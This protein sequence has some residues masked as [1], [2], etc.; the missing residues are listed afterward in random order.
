M[1]ELLKVWCLNGHCDEGDYEPELYSTYE[2]AKDAFDKH[3]EEINMCYGTY[4]EK[5]DAYE[6][7]CIADGDTASYDCGSHHGSFWIKEIDVQ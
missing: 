2:K 7:V 1:K 4:D 3:V 6:S 5:N